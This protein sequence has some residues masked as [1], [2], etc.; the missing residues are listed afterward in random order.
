MEVIREGLVV[1][2]D[3]SSALAELFAFHQNG[4]SDTLSAPL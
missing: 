1:T 3:S 4:G 2:V